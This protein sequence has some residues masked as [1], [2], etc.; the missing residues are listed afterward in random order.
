MKKW[1][2]VAVLLATAALVAGTAMPAAAATTSTV[3]VPDATQGVSVDA[4][5]GRVYVGTRPSPPPDIDPLDEWVDSAGV[6]QVDV[7][8]GKVVRSRTL[9]TSRSPIFA[10]AV[11]D[12]EVSSTSN[13]LWVLV[14]AFNIFSECGSTLYQLDKRSLAITRSYGIGCASAVELDPTSRT[15]YLV[16]GA[17]RIYNGSDDYQ[18][19][20]TLVAVN[21]ATGAVRKV[22]A[23]PSSGVGPNGDPVLP[24][25]I[26]FNARNQRLYLVGAGSA[27]LVYTPKLTLAGTLPL[28]YPTGDSLAVAA[29]P[30][31]NLVYVTDGA[32]VTEISG[33]TGK[34]TRTAALSGGGRVIDVG[35][36][37]L[38]LGA[39]TV[40][41]S[42]LQSVGQRP[43]PVQA[44]N[45]LTH[46]RYSVAP[47]QLYVDR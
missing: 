20:A 11:A 23:K 1:T 22:D 44:V 36:N 13:D 42:T 10:Y 12:V 45:P 28:D 34:A 39:N 14:S 15:A 16:A 47:G 31:T 35:A 37:V 25:S 24:T 29:N 43:R 40:K 33:R 19:E 7:K 32:K 41:L 30:V 21:G 17:D 18:P 4:L 5:S 26:A 3:T 46:V 27:A 38:Y 8:T 2:P 6:A 9:L